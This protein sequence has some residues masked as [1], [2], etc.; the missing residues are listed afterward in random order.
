[1]SLKGNAVKV[2]VTKPNGGESW[3]SGIG[4]S[5]TWQTSSTIAPAVATTKIY[6]TTNGGTTWKLITTLSGPTPG[7]YTWYIPKE[8]TTKNKC[9]VKVVLKNAANT[10]IGSDMSDKVFKITP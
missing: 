9:K 5:V 7:T 10:T 2:K 3:K 8:T 1:V 4:H 6:Y